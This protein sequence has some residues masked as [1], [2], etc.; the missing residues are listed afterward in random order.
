MFADQIDVSTDMRQLR[1]THTA[2]E[3]ELSSNTM[4]HAERHTVAYKEHD[5]LR[6][7]Y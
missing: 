7:I 3:T 2:V 5:H 4:G 6:I 1:T